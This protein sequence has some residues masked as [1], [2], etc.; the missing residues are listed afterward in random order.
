MS[1]SY[2]P[3]VSIVI[4]TYNRYQELME[5]LESVVVQTAVDYILEVIIVDDGSTDATF[6]QLTEKIDMG[7][8]SPL[9]I[10]VFKTK[11]QGVSC[12]RNFGLSL[13]KGSLIAFLDSDDRWLPNKL[14]KQM[15][16]FN[17]DELIDFLGCNAV[18]ESLK[19]PFRIVKHL[20]RINI[21]DL[22]LK[23][24]PTTPSI[25]MKR[26]I[27]LE[28]GG[29]DETITRFEDCDYWQRMCLMGYNMCHLQEELVSLSSKHPFGDEGLSSDLDGIAED[30]KKSITNLRKNKK[31]SILSYF[32]LRIFTYLKHVRRRREAKKWRSKL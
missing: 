24:F 18:G 28:M 13:A 6:E 26:R 30:V 32:L 1:T 3:E 22:W 21:Y 31:I 10:R 29:F 20:H 12:A 5:A 23:S 2:N 9:I 19:L 4:P 27:F 15:P 25:I 14:E 16:Y 11:N 7:Y 8:Y 17:K